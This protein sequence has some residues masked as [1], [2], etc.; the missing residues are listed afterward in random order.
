MRTYEKIKWRFDYFNKLVKFL[1]K[2]PSELYWIMFFLIRLVPSSGSLWEKR[3]SKIY[4]KK[5]VCSAEKERKIL[6]LKNNEEILD[7][8]LFKIVS[9]KN[10]YT[11]I[12]HQFFDLIYPYIVKSD[13]MIREGPYE[14]GAVELMLGDVVIDAG[15]FVGVFSIF[16]AKKVGPSGKVYAFEPIFENRELLTK[17][18]KLNNLDNLEIVPLALGKEESFL[19]MSAEEGKFNKSSGFFNTGKTRDVKQIS[20]DEFIEQRKISKV[21]FI[22]ADIEGMERELLIG[23]GKTIKKF[24]PCLAICTYHRP[25]DPKV[26]EEI[27]RSFGSEYKINHTE[28]KLYAWPDKIKITGISLVKNEDLYIERVLRNVI[29]FCDEIIVLDNMSSD[30][31]FEIVSKLSQICPKIKLFKIKDAFR[32]H[33]FIEKYANTNTWIFN[34]D[35]DEIYDP[36]GL[37]KLKEEILS[38]KYRDKWMIRGNGLHCEEI[39]LN[40][41]IVKG[42]LSPPSRLVPQIWN[43]SL[44]ESWIEK[45]SQ[46]LHGT[47]LVFKKGYDISLVYK[48]SDY[49]EWDSSHFRALHLCFLKRTSLNNKYKNLARL[50]PQEASYFFPMVRNFISNLSKKR[51]TFAS[52]YK[53]RKYKQGKLVVKDIQS[54]F[55]EKKL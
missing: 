34:I 22:K 48:I 2:K 30:S 46:R 9:D 19:R 20:L 28:M 44:L 4:A 16:A 49:Y 50:S 11:T 7:L 41:K 13:F 15:A 10:R 43:F 21:D 31:T 37:K 40:L 38:G 35:G 23:A 33:K 52:A 17:T 12:L 5:F 29:D 26:I 3:I 6:N 47:N 51:I 39:N 14:K 54:F 25:D 55:P 24:K 18:I 42:Y 1:I 45:Y 53:L 36:S 8:G 27:V 32:S